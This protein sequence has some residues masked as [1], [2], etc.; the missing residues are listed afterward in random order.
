MLAMWCWAQPLGQPLILT[1]MRFVSG[2]VI[3]IASRR[4]WT[5]SV[6]PVQLGITSS[7]G[8]NEAVQERLEAM[9]ITAPLTKRI[10]VKMSGCPNGCAQHHIANIGF[11][12]SSI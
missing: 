9:K 2:S 5:A 7:S 10:H 11:Y 4:S 8:L 6:G 1:W 3:F 12:G